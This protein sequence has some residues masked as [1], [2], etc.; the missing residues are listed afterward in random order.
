[1]FAELNVRAFK[2]HDQR[3]LDADLL[4][5]FDN[6]GG[7]DVTLHDAAENVDQ[8]SF[9]L[10]VG[11]DDL[12]GFRD[13][14]DGG[15]AP[16][17]EEV[18]RLT[19]VVLDDVH[20][21]HGQAGTI[22]H[23]ADIAVQGDVGEVVLRGFDLHRVFFVVVAQ[24]TDTDVAEQRVL[25]EVDFGVEAEQVAF[26]CQ[27]QGID[28]EQRAVSFDECLVEVHQQRHRLLDLGDRKAKLEGYLAGLE[29]GQAN[30]WIHGFKEDLFRRFGR[31]FF[32][33]HPA[34]G[35]GHQG[36]PV[37]GAVNQE[38]DVELVGDIAAT[39]NQDTL[40][41]FAFRTGLVGDQR[42]A[43]HVAGELF[44]FIG[45]LGDLDAAALAA[46]AGMNLRLDG[47]RAVAEPACPVAR[48]VAVVDHVAFRDRNPEVTQDRFGL[49]LVNIHGY[50]PSAKNGFLAGTPRPVFAICQ[51]DR[52]DYKT[53][54][55]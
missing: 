47:I 26:G 55:R 29:S 11:E 24:V 32:D 48:R 5:R 50:L 39:L 53:F 38:R 4:G 34:F 8:D 52:I 7:D 1:M 44:D 15:A 6:P 27:D 46:A 42:H 36:D 22:D 45:G 49:V 40:D 12:E 51:T 17:I 3:N 19:A 2:T 41:D 35:R 23:A 18:G 21:C 28:L 16:D 13:T 31:D 25:I 9:D 14:F 20:G 33:V 30:R 43:E 37:G 54:P 10:V